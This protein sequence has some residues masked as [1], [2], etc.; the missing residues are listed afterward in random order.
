MAYRAKRWR[1]G[2]QVRSNW[3]WLRVTRSWRRVLA[4]QRSHSSTHVLCGH[5]A[6]MAAL[7]KVVVHESRVVHPAALG[8]NSMASR[9]VPFAGSRRASFRRFLSSFS[10]G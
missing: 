9:F 10:S 6:A 7:A 3:V 4:F 1:I 5:L 2:C 8:G